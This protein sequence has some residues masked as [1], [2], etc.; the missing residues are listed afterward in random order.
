MK[1]PLTLVLDVLWCGN[2]RGEY[3]EHPLGSVARLQW[4]QDVNGAVF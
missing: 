1:L 2:G 3:K 4:A